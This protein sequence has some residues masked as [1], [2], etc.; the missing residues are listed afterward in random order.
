MSIREPG[1]GAWLKWCWPLLLL[2]GM[3]SGALVLLVS[4]M[5]ASAAEVHAPPPAPEWVYLTCTKA[6]AHKPSIRLPPGAKI[7]NA[8]IAKGER[9]AVCYTIISHDD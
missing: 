6:D 1:V 3:G 5:R 8:W 2:W 7:I 4:E 9:T